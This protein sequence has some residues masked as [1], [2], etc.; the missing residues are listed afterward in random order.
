MKDPGG[1]PIPYDPNQKTKIANLDPG[2]GALISYIVWPW[3]ILMVMQEPK[4]HKF[5]RFH[6]FQAL[7]YGV[8]YTIVA[9][10]LGFVFGIIHLWFLGQLA[11]LAGWVLALLVGLKAKN[12][13][14]RKLPVI[15][16]Y[17][18]KYM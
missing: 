2:L 4:E 11:M 13:E 17:A 1:A 7:F 9:Q 5:Q 10:V 16:P 12:G 14:T 15:G 8:A 3:A 18:E 6:A